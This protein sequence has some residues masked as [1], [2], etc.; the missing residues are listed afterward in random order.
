MWETIMP[1]VDLAA[2]GKQLPA[3]PDDNQPAIVEVIKGG[4]YVKGN[5]VVV[6]KRAERILDLCTP[7][8]RAAV[9]ATLPKMTDQGS[10]TQ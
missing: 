5:T 2:L 1:T 10:R 8:Q 4:G 7:E 3:L 9:M 6:S